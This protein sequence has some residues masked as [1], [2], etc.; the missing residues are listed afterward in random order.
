M[1]HWL[2]QKD[3]PFAVVA[4]PRATYVAK[5]GQSN[6]DYFVASKEIAALEKPQTVQ[7][8]GLAGHCPVR[9]SWSNVAFN[10]LVEVSMR[11]GISSPTP[12][13]GPQLEGM[14]SEETRDRIRRHLPTVP[15]DASSYCIQGM[16]H[17][18]ESVAKAMEIWT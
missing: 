4:Q 16:A 17:K 9:T 6:I 14:M 8:S 1:R 11:L 7:L 10:S 15:P 5:G 13:I 3:H 18:R 2:E 12:V